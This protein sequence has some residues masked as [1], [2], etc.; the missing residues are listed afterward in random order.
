ME[1]VG[2]ILRRYNWTR[3]NDSILKCPLKC[4]SPKST[5]RTDG[6]VTWHSNDVFGVKCAACTVIIFKVGYINSFRSSEVW[7]HDMY[8]WIGTVMV[9]IM[10]CRLYGTKPLSKQILSSILKLI[11]ISTIS[12]ETEGPGAS[13][14]TRILQLR[15]REFG[16]QIIYNTSPP[17]MFLSLDLLWEYRI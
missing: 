13:F 8:R 2:N 12:S 3:D 5:I 16:A 17:R 6:C 9:K 11:K 1:Y 4:I 7:R 14:M 10:T 15:F